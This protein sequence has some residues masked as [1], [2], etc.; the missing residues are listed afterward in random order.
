MQRAT[1]LLRFGVEEVQPGQ[2]MTNK[3]RLSPEIGDLI[4]MIEVAVEAGIVDPVGIELG[5]VAKRQ[6]LARFLQTQPD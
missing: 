6:Q 5:K 2:A 3:Q 1:K 4:V